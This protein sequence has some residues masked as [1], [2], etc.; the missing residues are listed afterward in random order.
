MS[1][2]LQRPRKEGGKKPSYIKHLSNDNL[3]I[4]NDK[5][6]GKEDR[7]PKGLNNARPPGPFGAMYTDKLVQQV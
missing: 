3:A 7:I 5:R 2:S 1:Q 6:K 4:L